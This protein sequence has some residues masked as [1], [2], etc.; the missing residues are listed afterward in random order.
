MAIIAVGIRTVA[1]VIHKSNVYRAL[2]IASLIS[3]LFAFVS[4]IRFAAANFSVDPI[5]FQMAA[6]FMV[7]FVLYF[8]MAILMYRDVAVHKG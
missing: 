8:V 3:V 7:A 4:G 2:S 5:S 1:L 6:G